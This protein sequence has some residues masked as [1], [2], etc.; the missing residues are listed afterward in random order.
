MQQA[1]LCSPQCFEK[2]A[3]SVFDQL[4]S[5]PMPD[6]AP[7]H[8][9]PLGL[10]MLERG[11]VSETQLRI[12][13]EMQTREQ[14]GKIGEWLQA[15]H[16]ATERQLLTALGIQWACPLLAMRQAPDQACSKLLPIPL[17]RALH[18]VPVRLLSATGFLYVAVSVG[19]N[20]RVLAAIEQMLDCRA[21]PCLIGDSTMEEW[22]RQVQNLEREV[23]VFDRTSGPPEMAR[24]TASY[25][26][27]LGAEEVRIVRCGPFMW[28]RLKVW[29][30][31]TDLLFTNKIRM[32]EEAVTI[33]W[34]PH[35]SLGQ[36]GLS[37]QHLCRLNHDA[38]GWRLLGFDASQFFAIEG[39]ARKFLRET[40]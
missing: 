19:V 6:S 3:R 20:Y 29:N 37:S 34:G 40:A 27:R 15:L 9:V 16:F 5:P 1:W 26:A 10:L 25:V 8:R 28:A 35:W 24:I 31:A 23:Q 30:S 4:L 36:I 14:R 7:K 12:A 17:M 33:S 18:L 21:I 38:A 13:L 22:L 32:D 2:E 39:I 11:Y